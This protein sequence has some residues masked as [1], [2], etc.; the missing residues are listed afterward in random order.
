MLLFVT[1][2]IQFENKLRE[3]LSRESRL[4]EKRKRKLSRK[5]RPRLP[6]LRMSRPIN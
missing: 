1:R 5:R 3:K 2:W 6:K 4:E